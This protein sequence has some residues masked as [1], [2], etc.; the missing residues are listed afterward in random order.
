M[1]LNLLHKVVLTLRCVTLCYGNSYGGGLGV[2]PVTLPLGVLRC[3]ALG[4]VT[5]RGGRHG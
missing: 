5:P 2:T 3:Y 1:L 4:S